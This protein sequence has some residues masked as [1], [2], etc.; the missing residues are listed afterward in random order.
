MQQREPVD[1]SL[2]GRPVEHRGEGEIDERAMGN[3]DEPRYPHERSALLRR[4]DREIV[5]R[6]EDRVARLSRGRAAADELTRHAYPRAQVSLL[7]RALEA[8]HAGRRDD[9]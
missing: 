2:A 4:P 5:Q 1:Q 3:D 9:E 8:P 7:D 6:A